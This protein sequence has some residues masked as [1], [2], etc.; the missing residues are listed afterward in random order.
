MANR[1]WVGGSG[2][3]DSTTTTHWSLTSGGT[4]NQGPPTS[5]DDVIFDTNSNAK[6]GRAHV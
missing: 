1:Y 3:W 6:I 4:G 2:T 5:A